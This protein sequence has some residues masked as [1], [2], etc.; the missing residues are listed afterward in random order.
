MAAS[1]IL[2]VDDEL[3]IRIML[4][5]MIEPLKHEVYCAEDGVMALEMVR[6]ASID[7]VISDLMM[8]RMDGLALLEQVRNEGYDCAFIILTGF[9]DLPQALT[10]RE[11]FNISNFLVKPIHNMD[12]FLF[13][14]ESALSRRLLERENRRLLQR[15]QE[16]NA[17]LEEKVLERTR[18]LE[19]KAR[20]LSRVSKFRADALKVLGH[21]LRTPLAILSG[22]AALA[23]AGGAEELGALVPAM[24]GSIGRL[25]HIVDRAL[26]LLKASEAT[27]FP[28]E[29]TEVFPGGLCRAV[30]ERIQPFIGERR[31]GLAPPPPCEAPRACLWDREKMEEVVEELLINAIRASADGSRIEMDV[32]S[33]GGTVVISIKD[34]GVGIPESQRERIF[35]PFVTLRKA[36]HHSSGLFEFGAEGVGIG[37]STARMWVGL[38]GGTIEAHGNAGHPGTTMVV[39]MPCQPP[40]RE[41]GPSRGEPR[42]SGAPRD[43]ESAA[44]GERPSRA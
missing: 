39:R 31:L 22:Y 5:R 15:L 24:G 33:E 8:P 34:F 28:L 27:E 29:P 43:A 1:K 3:S 12:Q 4:S 2:I 32:R 6:Q 16:V 11:K 42:A 36:E 14:V 37:L 7:L 13:D 38:H 21:E 20:E 18:E 23:S 9:G 44:A 40:K 30:V 17:R 25:Q 19:V 41:A 26:G 35:E 10:A